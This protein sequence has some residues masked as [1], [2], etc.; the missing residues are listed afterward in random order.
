MC[1]CNPHS[2]IYHVTEYRYNH[3][4]TSHLSCDRSYHRITRLSTSWLN[5]DSPSAT[6]N[7]VSINNAHDAKTFSPTNKY[8]DGKTSTPADDGSFD[9]AYNSSFKNSIDRNVS[10]PSNEGSSNCAE[11]GNFSTPSNKDVSN[12]GKNNGDQDQ[13][14]GSVSIDKRDSSST[15]AITTSVSVHEGAGA[16]YKEL[17]LISL[18]DIAML[19]IVL[20]KLEF[21]CQSAIIHCIFKLIFI[22]SYLS[23]YID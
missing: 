18:L 20:G 4:Y 14:S 5:D 3:S 12:N 7:E 17:S 1:H 8:S 9:N 23:V 13:I 2:Q 22:Y 10:T 15:M 11:D 21:A 16:H 19:L 6:G